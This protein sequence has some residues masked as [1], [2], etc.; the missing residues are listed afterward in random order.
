MTDSILL[1][2]ADQGLIGPLD[3]DKRVQLCTAV[4]RHL[5]TYCGLSPHGYP[6]LAHDEH[7]DAICQVL[8][9]SLLPL[10][11]A[12]QCLS[13][14]SFTCIVHDRFNRQMVRDATGAYSELPETNPVHS[15]APGAESLSVVVTL[16]CNTYDNGEGW[17]Y[18]WIR[19]EEE[20]HVAEENLDL[21][22]ASHSEGSWIHGSEDDHSGSEI[23]ISASS[24]D[25]PSYPAPSAPA[26]PPTVPSAHAR[27]RAS[28]FCTPWF[29]GRHASGDAC[30][31]CA[32]PGCESAVLSSEH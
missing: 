1:A 23:S 32:A 9:V 7:F 18:E 13:Q 15:A 10:W 12:E 14:T 16:Y 22:S 25:E 29:Q 11:L 3:K 31:D 24:D 5:V 19:A 21:S 2:M 4:R 28:V 20:G 26:D 6:F 17:H 27:T 30:I 8:R